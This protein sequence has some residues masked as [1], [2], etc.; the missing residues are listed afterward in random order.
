MYSILY[1]K[2]V[3]TAGMWINNRALFPSQ[4][5]ACLSTWQSLI[6]CDSD[7]Y[8]LMS[9]DL[10]G[11][12]K[13]NSKFYFESATPVPSFTLCIAVGKWDSKVLAPISES[14]LSKNAKQF[15]CFHDTPCPITYC[16]NEV[17]PC[18]IY[19]PTSRLQLV[20]D[21]LKFTLHRCVDVLKKFL[22]PHPFYRM[23]IVLFPASSQD[24][25]F[26]NPNIL[27]LSESFL[28]ND[29]RFILKLVHEISHSWFG[30]LIGAKDWTEEWL[31]EGFATFVEDLLIEELIENENPKE[32]REIRYRM[33]L[34]TLKSE[35]AHTDKNLQA[36]R[37][38]K[39]EDV[40]ENEEVKFIKNGMNPEKQF[41]Q[42]HY[43][44][45]YFLLSYLYEYSGA[46]SF[47]L[48]LRE[49]VMLY[50]GSMVN[51]KDVLTLF[52]RMNPQLEDPIKFNDTYLYKVWL[53]SAELPECL[54]ER[55]DENNTLYKQCLE[56]E[57]FWKGLKLR[58]SRKKRKIDFSQIRKMNCFQ[59]EL[60]LDLI[61]RWTSKRMNTQCMK[62]LNEVYRFDECNADIRHRWSELVIRT[63]YAPAFDELRNFLLNNQAMG[64]YL[65]GEA[66]ILGSR[67]LKSLVI[68]CFRAI[69]DEM[70]EGARKAVRVM[71][72]GEE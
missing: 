53:D 25:A 23:D 21:N 22:G 7:Y 49:Y 19:A 30:L 42:V 10:E 72:F 51:S 15:E 56:A 70:E 61:I 44:K 36:L 34:S 8:P 60:L 5:Y 63:D 67:R 64:V 39:G 27:F 4:E 71:L 11:S 13:T 17:L 3:Y 24:L 40:Y 58:K 48:F 29:Y 46:E 37:P 14:F 55:L 9:S 12:R 59:L 66:S 50:H 57:K 35:L 65:Y 1:S 32:I 54:T 69:E 31:S 43:L 45:G 41:T 62:H 68:E 2:C 47:K 6:S 33:R 28:S 38:N 20:Y 52:F 26:A 18:T 16:L